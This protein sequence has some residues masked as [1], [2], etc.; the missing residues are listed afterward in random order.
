MQITIWVAATC[1]IVFVVT[2]M[3]EF[4][5]VF[6]YHLIQSQLPKSVLSRLY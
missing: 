6:I 5:P 4:L 1:V 2:L 3:Q